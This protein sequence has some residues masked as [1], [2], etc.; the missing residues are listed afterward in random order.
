MQVS[1]CVS[2]EGLISY[3]CLC[4]CDSVSMSVHMFV[5]TLYMLQKGRLNV[6]TCLFIPH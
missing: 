1:L 4:L 6:Q 2:S 3:V 5:C